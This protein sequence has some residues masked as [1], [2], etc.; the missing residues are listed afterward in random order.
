MAAPPGPTTFQGMTP[1]EG[2]SLA[3]GGVVLLILTCIRVGVDRVRTPGALTETA[4]SDLPALLEKSRNSRDEERRR[5]L[6]LS[7]GETLDPNQ[8]GEEEF[9]RLP[10][11]GP[12]VARAL[13]T[14]REEVGRYHGPEDLL[15]VSGV[16]PATLERIR[17]YLEFPGETRFP[18]GRETAEN[19]SSRLVDLNRA[20]SQELQSLSGIGPSLAGKILESRAR[21]GPF[22]SPEDLLRVPGIGP[23][24]LARLRPLISVGRGRS[25]SP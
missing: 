1:M 4:S 10:G 25:F 8:S 19:S 20:S 12:S 22:R 14:H 24:T 15:A 13:V 23:A 6:P 9:D 16:G 18:R 2:R 21:D 11:V 7:P 5:S 3:R 17:P